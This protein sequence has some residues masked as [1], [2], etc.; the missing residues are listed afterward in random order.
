MIALAL[1]L[2]VAVGL[3][4]SALVAFARDR[5]STSPPGWGALAMI[6]ALPIIGP[7]IYLST[8]RAGR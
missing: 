5:G 7:G 4:L 3:G 1:V 8:R 6:V 2:V